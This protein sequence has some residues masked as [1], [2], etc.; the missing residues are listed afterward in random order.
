MKPVEGATNAQPIPDGEV[1]MISI[2]V[3]GSV[4]EPTRILGLLFAIALVGSDPLPVLA[5]VSGS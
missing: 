3:Q 1:V 5:Q 4:A 2:K